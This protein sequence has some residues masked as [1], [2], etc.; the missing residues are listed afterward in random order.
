[1]ETLP[2]KTPL[3]IL[4]LEDNP[5]DR[6]LL[7][8]A[9]QA[10]G[11]N[12]RFAH[13]AI[14]KD[15]ETALRREP[16]DLIISDYSLPGYNGMEALAAARARQPDTPFVLVSGT[17]GEERAVESLK[18]GA[19]DCVLKNNL[20]RLGPVIRRALNEAGERT[21]RR[22]AEETLRRQSEQLRALTA[23]LQASREEERIQIAREIHDELGEALTGLKLG[24]AWIRRRLQSRSNAI[25]WE[26]VFGR[27]DQLGSLADATAD[28]VRKVCAKLRPDILDHLGLVP[29]IQWQAREFQTRTNIRCSV[30]SP[31]GDPP[32]REDQAIAIFRVF[33]EILTNVARHACASRVLVVLKK[34]PVNLQ[35]RV[36]DNGRGIQPGKIAGSPSLGLLGMRERVALLGGQLDIHSRPGRGTTVNVT[37]PLN[38]CSAP[39]G[40]APSPQPSPS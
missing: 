23:R 30:R 13:V 12:A 15:F 9:L 1:M 10:D 7:A 18:S 3:R 37:L 14:R 36:A 38:F 39:P 28:R 2:I 32:V 5:N 29:A 6:E 22:N 11:V 33:Q 27:M 20:A 40:D 19:T 8:A 25:P 17:I 35:L 4:C 26:Q 24:L 21:Q 34:T 31:A 16:F